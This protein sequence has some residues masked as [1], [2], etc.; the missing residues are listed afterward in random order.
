MKTSEMV[1]EYLKEQGFCPKVDEDGDIVFKF[2][3]LTFVY[4]E[5]DDDERF[6][7]FG[8][9]NIFQVTDDNRMMVLEAV[10]ELNTMIKVVKAFVVRNSVWLSTESL[11]DGTP[12][13]DDIVP[14]LLDILFHARLKF[15]QLIEE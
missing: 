9:P 11:L 15:A 6:F 7:R 4:F 1:F 2:Q 5:D 3:M 10:N 12:Q 14:R 8:V 13:L